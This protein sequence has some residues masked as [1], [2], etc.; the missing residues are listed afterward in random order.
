[1]ASSDI[2]IEKLWLGYGRGN[3]LVLTHV[4]SGIT[5]RSTPIRGDDPDWYSRE[6]AKLLDELKR[7]LKDDGHGD[8]A[9]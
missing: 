4:P 8:E 1:V 5:I 9:I 3:Q 2:Y 7:R 6:E